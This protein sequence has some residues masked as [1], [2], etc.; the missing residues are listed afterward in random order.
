MLFLE[1]TEKVTKEL[2]EKKQQKEMVS[3][4]I[5]NRS[6]KTRWFQCSKSS[7]RFKQEGKT[8]KFFIVN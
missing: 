8:L 5:S 3:Q 6:E 2:P 1:E 4:G 7:K